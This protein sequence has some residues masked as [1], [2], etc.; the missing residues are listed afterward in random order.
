MSFW[1]PLLLAYHICAGRLACANCLQWNLKYNCNSVSWLWKDLC[2]ETEAFVFLLHQH[3]DL[4]F[5]ASRIPAGPSFY[6]TTRSSSVQ[7]LLFM[8]EC[9]FEGV[10]AIDWNGL[11]DIKMSIQRLPVLVVLNHKSF[12]FYHDWYLYGFHSTH[13]AIC[14]WSSLGVGES[15]WLSTSKSQIACH[16]HCPWPNDPKEI[17]NVVLLC[18][19]AAPHFLS[20][21][22]VHLTVAFWASVCACVKEWVDRPQE[23]HGKQSSVT[24]KP[25]VCPFRDCPD[26]LRLVI[27]ERQS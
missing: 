15:I 16:R 12:C 19:L 22:H 24:F 4:I 1:H 2:L 13:T 6:L 5:N 21:P 10:N 14:S 11:V 7:E 25:C 17:C 3:F 8:W 27:W 23:C 26:S 20:S 9:V 18:Q